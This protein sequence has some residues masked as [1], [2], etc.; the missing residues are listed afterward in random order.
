LPFAARFAAFAALA[1]R[2]LAAAAFSFAWLRLFPP[3]AE[4]SECDKPGPPFI[5]LLNNKTSGGPASAGVKF[6]SEKAGNPFLA[7]SVQ[8]FS[9]GQFFVILAGA[10]SFVATRAATGALLSRCGRTGA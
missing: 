9:A 8:W 3:R 2:K 6:A 10:F 4:T 1:R 5:A 7:S